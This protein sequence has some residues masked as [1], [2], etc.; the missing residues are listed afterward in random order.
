[1]SVQRVPVY[2]SQCVAGPDLIQ[3]E[4]RDGVAE[5]IVP[6]LD[7]LARLGI[8]PQFVESNT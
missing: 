5:R 8:R 7:E 3:V 2:C 4:V 6:A 1:M